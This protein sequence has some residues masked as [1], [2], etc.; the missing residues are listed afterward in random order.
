[1]CAFRPI[2][3]VQ[4]FD[5]ISRGVADFYAI[6]QEIRARG[7]SLRSLFEQFDTSTPMGKAMM[8]FAAVWAELEADTTRERVMNGLCAARARGVKLG[9]R[10]ILSPSC[11][12]AIRSSLTAGIS[13]R[14]LAV[15]AIAQ[16]GDSATPAGSALTSNKP[17]RPP[18]GDAMLCP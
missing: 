18:A 2:I 7:A 4:R 8:G 3:T 16:S 10:Y 17:V 1:M 11:E 13:A 14:Q 6:G 5:R 15:M 12:T 9:R